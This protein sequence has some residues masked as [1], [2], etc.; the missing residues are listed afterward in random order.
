MAS[1]RDWPGPRGRN[2]QQ[3]H[4]MHTQ[5]LLPRIGNSDPG[6]NTTRSLAQPQR[7]YLTLLYAK[8]THQHEGRSTQD[9]N[10][11]AEQQDSINQRVLSCHVSVYKPQ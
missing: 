4:H 11:Q 2:A 8:R 5:Q 3:A 1:H 6:H 10:R 7:I 9:C